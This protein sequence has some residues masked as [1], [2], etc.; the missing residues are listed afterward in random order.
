MKIISLNVIGLG[1]GFEKLSLKRNF[2]RMDPNVIRLQE[3]MVSGAKVQE[4]LN[5]YPQGL[6]YSY[7]GI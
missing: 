4:A 7:Y 1:V 5:F 3:T 6:V 2:R